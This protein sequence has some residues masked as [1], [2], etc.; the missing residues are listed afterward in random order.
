MSSAPA[1][2]S[3]FTWLI[4]FGGVTWISVGSRPPSFPCPKSH[5]PRTSCFAGA[6]HNGKPCG[7]SRLGWP[8]P[9]DGLDA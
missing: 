6:T 7:R 1:G 8:F 5:R 4:R 9:C 3:T 2:H